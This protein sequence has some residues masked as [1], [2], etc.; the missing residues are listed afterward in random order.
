MAQYSKLVKQTIVPE[1]IQ[2]IVSELCKHWE[3]GNGYEGK[4]YVGKEQYQLQLLINSNLGEVAAFYL[5]QQQDFIDE[6]NAF[7]ADYPELAYNH[8]NC[9][10]YTF[11]NATGAQTEAAHDILDLSAPNPN[12][13]GWTDLIRRDGV[14]FDKSA[15]WSIEVKNTTTTSSRSPSGFHKADLVLVFYNDTKAIEALIPM[16]NERKQRDDSCYIKLGTLSSTADPGYKKITKDW[17][18]IDFDEI[19][20]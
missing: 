2:N 12:K 4:Q 19:L 7:L 8:V 10:E 3:E 11:N 18:I 1:D 6:L 20:Y 15:I 16:I 14:S 9:N 17:Q 13:K 5:L